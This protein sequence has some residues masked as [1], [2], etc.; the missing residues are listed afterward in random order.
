MINT[1]GRRPNTRRSFAYVLSLDSAQLLETILHHSQ[2]TADT[3]TPEL[4]KEIRAMLKILM[5]EHHLGL[6]FD[7]LHIKFQ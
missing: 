1:A 3:P 5:H 6:D 2:V 4:M 7:K